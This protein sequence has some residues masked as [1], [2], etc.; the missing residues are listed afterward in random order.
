MSHIL[1]YQA[2]ISCRYPI[3]S[4]WKILSR[5]LCPYRELSSAVWIQYR[6]VQFVFTF[7]K[8]L[9]FYTEAFKVCWLQTG[10]WSVLI[11][12]II[13]YFKISISLRTAFFSF[14]YSSVVGVTS[15]R[16]SDILSSSHRGELISLLVKA[17]STLPILSSSSNF[18]T[19]PARIPKCISGY[20]S[21][22]TCRDFGKDILKVW[23]HLYN[24]LFTLAVMRVQPDP[25]SHYFLAWKMSA[26]VCVRVMDS[27]EAAFFPNHL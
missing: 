3:N 11:L 10:A 19:T 5:Y 25:W 8:S 21:L 13:G 22:K 9:S 16:W 24:I 14:L 18:V 27:P 23:K 2:D 4:E 7:N 15:I 26:S 20:F 6:S 17:I 1:H 12:K